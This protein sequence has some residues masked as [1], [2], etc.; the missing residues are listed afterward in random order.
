AVLDRGQPPQHLQIEVRVTLLAQG[1]AHV[2]DGRV[3]RDQHVAVRDHVARVALRE[4]QG[5]RKGRAD[6]RG[7]PIGVLVG[8]EL[9]GHEPA[10]PRNRLRLSR[11]KVSRASDVATRTYPR[12][13]KSLSRKLRQSSK[14][15]IPVTSSRPSGTPFAAKKSRYPPDATQNFR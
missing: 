4:D 12:W 3:L 5:G 2:H 15:G 6:L 7:G 13:G 10:G 11:L 14:F 8:V 1:E 9:A